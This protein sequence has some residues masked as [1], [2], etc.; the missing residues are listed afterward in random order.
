MVVDGFIVGVLIPLS[1]PIESFLDIEVD[2]FIVG[3]LISCS[4]DILYSSLYFIEDTDMGVGVADL[5]L[6]VISFKD[7][8][9]DFILILKLLLL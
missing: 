2:E 4:K 6:N 9:F 3:V 5:L 8:L 1:V 7:G